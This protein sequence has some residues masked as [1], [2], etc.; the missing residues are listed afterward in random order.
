MA[1]ANPAVM[2]LVAKIVLDTTPSTQV[3]SAEHISRDAN[4]QNQ[5]GEI[6]Q[7]CILR[8]PAMR[9]SIEGFDEI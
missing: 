5:H 9:N 8:K 7:V 6:I 4:A 1:E 3:N 2:L